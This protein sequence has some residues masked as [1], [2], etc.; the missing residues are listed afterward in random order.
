ML[1]TRYLLFLLLPVQL[2]CSYCFIGGG[3]DD[4]DD[5]DDD[6]NDDDDDDCSCCSFWASDLYVYQSYV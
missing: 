2:Y 6:D 1:S 4:D 5:D 3:D